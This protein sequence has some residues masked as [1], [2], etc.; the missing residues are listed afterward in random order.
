MKPCPGRARGAG[1]LEPSE[2]GPG[3]LRMLPPGIAESTRSVWW[4]EG[5]GFASR[6]SGLSF[7]ST[8]VRQGSWGRTLVLWARVVPLPPCPWEHSGPHRHFANFDNIPW[9]HGCSLKARHPH[10]CF[11]FVLPLEPAL[12]PTGWNLLLPYFT[13][14]E[15]E[16]WR[17][18][19]ACSEFADSEQGFWCG[20]PVAGLLQLCS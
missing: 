18:K 4:S 2:A 14:K 20:K 19:V 12:Q 13:A 5:L 16:A 7:L 15:T 1:C 3:S 17:G 8:G 10:E 9:T 6:V 11:E